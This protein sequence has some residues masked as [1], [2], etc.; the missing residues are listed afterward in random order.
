MKQLNLV[1]L[2]GL[3]GL[4]ELCS[5]SQQ[6]VVPTG[7]R[8]TSAG[9]GPLAQEELQKHPGTPGDVQSGALSQ[10]VHVSKNWVLRVL[11]IFIVL[12]V[13]GRYRVIQYMD[14]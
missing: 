12:Q 4:L 3:R 5:R 13:L 8:F 9:P 14:P 6:L 1:R 7:P 2:T 10:R 11:V